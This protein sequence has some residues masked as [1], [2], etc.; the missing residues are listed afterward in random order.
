MLGIIIDVIMF[1]ARFQVCVNHIVAFQTPTM[2]FVILGEIIWRLRFFGLFSHMNIEHDDDDDD[3]DGGGGGAAATA[4]AAS[5][6]YIYSY[7]ESCI[8]GK[9]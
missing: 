8:V 6:L 4:A 2:G 5:E 3:D 1:Q 9:C 7:Q